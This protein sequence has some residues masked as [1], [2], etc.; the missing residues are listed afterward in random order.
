MVDSWNELDAYRDRVRG[1]FRLRLESLGDKDLA[2]QR[3]MNIDGD[4]IWYSPAE[5]FA[6]VLLHERQHHG[7]LNTLFYQL[8]LAPPVVEFRFS[9]PGRRR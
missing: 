4:V 5:I 2:A 7:D 8:G 6:H 1:L 3:E 9:L